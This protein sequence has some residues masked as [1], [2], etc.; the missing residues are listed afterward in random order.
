MR[1]EQIEAVIRR[2]AHGTSF[3]RDF[4]WL[5]K[6]YLDNAPLYRG[7]FRKVW[8]WDEWPDRWGRDCG[9]DL[10]AETTDGE[11]WA[12][13]CKAVS[14][15][16]TVTKAEIDSFLSESNRKQIAYR[17]LIATTDN[18]GA[19]ALRTI[20]NQACRASVVLRGDLVTAELDWP[21]TIG[22]TAPKPPRRKPLPHQQAAIK[23]AVAG[24]KKHDR[25]RLIMACGTG[26]T[27]T[28]LWVNEAL[29]SRRTLLLV[30]SI[31]LAQQNLKEWGRHAKE[32]FDCLVV[33]SDETVASD[34]DDPALRYVTDLGIKPTTAPGEIAAFLAKRRSRPTLVISTYQSCERV[35]RGQAKAKKWFDL[36][37]CDEAHRLVGHA[38]SQFA[39]VL[40]DK[41]IRARRRL[42]MTATPRYF[43][44]QAK[45][46]GA[47]QEIELV[48]M[49]DETKFGPEFHVLT[50]HEAITAK[51][52]PLLT[53]YQVVVIGVTSAEAKAWA[54]DAKL[55]RT[56][57]G[58]ETDA[59]T[60]AAQIGLAK[61]V[62][63]YDLSR[64]ITFHRSIRRAS[65]FVDVERRDSLP[66]VIEKMRPA[67]R[68][69]G[70]LWARHVSGETAAS[71][72][73]S[74]LRELGDL[75]KG[76]RALISN[77]ACLGEGVDVPALDGIAFIDPKGSVVDIIQAVGRV[78]RKS[79]DKKIGT[80]IIPVFVDETEDADHALESSA[81]QPVWQVL[82]ALR[83]HD[84]RLA[85]DID[86]LRRSLGSQSRPGRRI[87]LPAKIVLDVPRLLLKDFEQAFYVRAVMA[88]SERPPLTIKQILVW[89]DEHKAR[90][91]EWPQATS[92]PIP[93]SDEIWARID[94]ALRAGSRGLAG[95]ASL[96]A[97]LSEHRG[98]RNLKQLPSLSMKQI[99]D[100][101]DA[102]KARH[103][104]WPD[105][106]SGAI[107]GTG[108]TW[109][110]IQH[111]LRTGRRGLPGG[112]TL[113]NL[114]ASRR[115]VRN[116]QNLAPLRI[117]QIL[118]WADEYYGRMREWPNRFSGAVQGT[119]ET[120]AGVNGALALGN[121]GLPGGT[122]L[123]QLLAERR[124]VRNSRDLSP[125]TK[126]QIL[127]WA[128]AHRK[129]T[130]DWPTRNSGAI[131]GTNESWSQVNYALV[132]G[133]RGLAGGTTLA[134]LLDLR[135]GVV[136]I[137]NQESL[138]ERRILKWADDF[139]RRKGRWP[140]QK[141]GQ[142]DGGR[143][144]WAAI[145]VALS[146]GLRGLA[147]G[148][149]LARLL[150]EHRG[151]RN[152][153]DLP[154]L[155][156]SLILR[157]ADE[158]KAATGNWP[159]RTSGDCG[160]D[161]DTWSRV[162]AALKQGHRGLPGGSSLAR[163]LA[164]HRGAPNRKDLPPLTIKQ[165]LR[166]AD[167]EYA[168][169]GNWPKATSTLIEGTRE[170]WASVNAALI[171]GHR[172]LPGGFTLANLLQKHRRGKT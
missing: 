108:D 42:F 107:D 48:S 72:R 170:T 88:A 131:R 44:Q 97:V 10:V 106:Y 82:K 38:E 142:I 20:E 110:A 60:L 161:G 156:A 119:T 73:A 99:L 112:D 6:W 115:R 134:Q 19:N 158:F 80:I 14:P 116:V 139:F 87:K 59:R 167:A 159:T 62:K 92:G 121:R 69:S 133:T 58:L 148:S 39:T 104:E 68:P 32:D 57:D 41:K 12:V 30:P 46:R 146:R 29:G 74:L 135:R 27:L 153:R 25:G 101:A 17:L 94:A 70:R 114:L 63:Q 78:I 96:P 128:D 8:R 52:E 77:C 54:G 143:E 129:A 16:H 22:G 53:D 124:G 33:C 23:D 140:A 76:T 163:L 86:Q 18:I 79:P 43:T 147:G 64:M 84:R 130:G 66:A 93:Q 127:Q 11:L 45:D 36:A 37:I 144:T 71:K 50:F 168:S 81:F 35:S 103:G 34:R 15:E 136:N 56:K 1:F 5:C 122:T 9:I 61:A 2:E 155:R 105:Q 150:A 138:T 154:P 91:G 47:E 166:W 83:A 132:T 157:W 90:T 85:D 117:T 126:R 21:S 118:A 172:G 89:A 65:R 123:A 165:I 28:G 113:A 109:H 137:H 151:K 95:G 149:S 4:E 120:W 67:N 13:Q 169:S 98:V 26:K 164:R 24:F 49:D 75:P 141:S 7:Q 40:H 152:H 100:W 125:L 145:D 3:G 111:A 31:S 102:H 162:D 51:P 160:D 55:V 171:R